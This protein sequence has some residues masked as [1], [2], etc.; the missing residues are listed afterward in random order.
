MNRIRKI[1]MMESVVC[2]SWL[3]FS[4]NTILRRKIHNPEKILSLYVREGETVIDLG[5]GPGFFIPGLAEAVGKTGKVFAVDI[6]KKAVDMIRKKINRTVYEDIVTPI[7][8]GG[9]SI[10]VKEKADFAFMFW[11]L[12]EVPDKKGVLQ[13]LKSVMKPG[14]LVLLV[15]PKI[16]VSKKTFMEEISIAESCDMEKVDS[17]GISLSMTALFRIREDLNNKLKPD[18]D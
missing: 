7:L 17:P 5:C 16:H 4:L 1:L 2:P 13:Q 3:Y 11:M 8:S 6:Q 18:I 14:A 10:P 12:H 9:R 15:E